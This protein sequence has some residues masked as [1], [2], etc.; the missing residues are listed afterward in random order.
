MSDAVLVVVLM[1]FSHLLADFV[2]QNDWI[3][4]NKGTGGR[5]GWSALGLHGFHVGLCLSPIVLAFGLRGL[6]A[7]VL[8]VASHMV[9]DRWKVRATR[10]ANLVAQAQAR[11]LI[12]RTGTAPASGLGAAWS[13]WPGILFIADQVLHV[14][15]LLVAWLV[16][17]SGAGLLPEFQQF[18]DTALGAWNLTTVHATILTGV[19]LISLAIVNTRGAFYFVMSL[20]TPRDLDVPSAVGDARPGLAPAATHEAR[21]P[22]APSASI[23][24]APA[25]ASGAATA[26]AR[27]PVAVADATPAPISTLAHVPDPAEVVV[28]TPGP[29]KTGVPAGTSARISAAIGALERLLVVAFVLAGAWVAVGLLLVVKTAAR[30]RQLRDPA[31]VEYYLVGTMASVSVAVL[32]AEAALGALHTIGL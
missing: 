2:L 8:V 16:F 30:F 20:L 25:D 9:V 10:Q 6:A 12:E 29:V 27:D 4:I 17:I 14:T 32:S 23:G 19:V 21:S 15:F 31:F 5:E 13:P 7:L 26:L 28:T 11:A 3:A 24:R 1:L 22:G 18:V